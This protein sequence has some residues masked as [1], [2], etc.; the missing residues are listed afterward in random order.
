[1]LITNITTAAPMGKSCV[2]MT[3]GVGDTN[4]GRLVLKNNVSERDLKE[5]D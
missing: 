2:A 4:N 5:K 3:V 1:M